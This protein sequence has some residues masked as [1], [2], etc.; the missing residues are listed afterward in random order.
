[1][2]NFVHISCH[3]IIRECP[4]SGFI[5]VVNATFK[6]NGAV[7]DLHRIQI[8]PNGNY[9]ANI[10]IHNRKDPN[11]VNITVYLDVYYRDSVLNANEDF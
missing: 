1:M 3:G 9:K 7:Q 10:A 8:F 6:N 4:Y 5:S 11:I 2:I